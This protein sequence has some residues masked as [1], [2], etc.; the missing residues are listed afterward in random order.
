MA[1]SRHLTILQI[2]DLHGYLEPHAEFVRTAAGMDYQTLGGLARIGGLFNAIRQEVGDG[3]IALDNGDTFHGTYVPVTSQGLAMVPM[4]NAL[5]LDAM[6]AHWEFAYGPAGFK[7]L[8]AQL[9]YPV[10]AINCFDK[11]SGD[12]VF[13]PY[14]VV[15]RAGLRL[16]IVGLA[17]PIVD[18][19]M[20]PSYSEGVRFTN[21]VDE[22]PGWIDHLRTIERVDLVIALSHLGYPQ[23]VA[24]AKR[25]NGIDVLVSGH[26]HN[27][28]Y[29]PVIENG[30]IIFQS[31]CHG[32]FIGR[33]DVE[34]SDS[35]VVGHRHQ[36]IPV[37]GDVPEDAAIA[38]LVESA[39][40]PHRTMLQAVVGAT[41]TPLHRYAMLQ[42]TMDQVLLD[43]VAAASGREIAF[44]NGWRYGAPIPPGPVTVADL[45]NIIPTN[46]PVSVV[47]LTGQEIQDMLEQNLERTF[48]ADPFDQ[49][50]GYVKRCRGL[51]MY[52]KA[53][54]PAG[55]RIERLFVGDKPVDAARIY[56]VAFV[57]TQGV[58]AKFG[59]NRRNLETYAVDALKAYFAKQS[60]VRLSPQETVTAV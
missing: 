33:L 10:L 58:P 56:E 8:A 15:E 13:A 45:W 50:G 32:A 53:E 23:D 25:V 43:A 52:L 48:A 49:M 30:A 24:L 19:T 39:V 57:T 2:N 4:M 16:G 28:M 47:D 35:K 41:E 55:H 46:P 3:V 5:G 11:A 36:L 31:G 42:S 17:C 18:K 27:R 29:E 59:T 21:G 44:S 26:T 1:S 9:N 22:L 20:P 37:D 51:H 6:T 34:V 7:H 12:L 60:P 38:G 14:L 54:S 40:G